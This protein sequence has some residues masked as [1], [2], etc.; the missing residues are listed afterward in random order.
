MAYESEYTQFI[1]AWLEKHPEE[2]A[3][4]QSGRALWWD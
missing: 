4:Q 3:V 1:R 2:R